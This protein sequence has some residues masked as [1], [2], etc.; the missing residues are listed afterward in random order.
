MRFV[1]VKLLCCCVSRF[2][3]ISLSPWTFHRCKF[4]YCLLF[5]RFLALTGRV[6]PQPLTVNYWFNLLLR[7]C[8]L[9]LILII[10]L[11]SQRTLSS[12]WTIRKNNSVSVRYVSV[13]YG[14]K[15]VKLTK[16]NHCHLW[17]FLSKH[18]LKSG[19]EAAVLSVPRR[20]PWFQWLGAI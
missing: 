9:F 14:P 7:I 11:R 4:R 17:E 2:T 6:V 1:Q 19:T 20:R 13:K 15:W 8:A 10:A 5:D 3:A 16:I 18:L 12:V